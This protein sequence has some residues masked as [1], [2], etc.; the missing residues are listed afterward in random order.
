MTGRKRTA[1]GIFLVVVDDILDI[2]VGTKEEHSKGFTNLYN[3]DAVCLLECAN[4]DDVSHHIRGLIKYSL[5]VR[6]CTV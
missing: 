5:A 6:I 3:A 4:S 2:T 1:Y